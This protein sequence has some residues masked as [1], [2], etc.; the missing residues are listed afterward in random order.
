MN[1]FKELS[2]NEEFVPAEEET[3]STNLIVGVLGILA[4]IVLGVMARYASIKKETALMKQAA[5]YQN[6][7]EQAEKED[8][9][10]EKRAKE[11]SVEKKKVEEEQDLLFR[12]KSDYLI[13]ELT[14]IFL[15]LQ[16]CQGNFRQND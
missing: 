10:E 14:S 4:L 1:L 16:S 5:D 9:E 12:L 15:R 13:E 3:L 2:T 11:D 7:Q 8:K 6:Q